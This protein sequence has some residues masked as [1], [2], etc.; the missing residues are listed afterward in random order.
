MPAMLHAAPQRRGSIASITVNY[1]ARANEQAIRSLVKNVAVM[2]ATTYSSGDPAAADR[3]AALGQRI[4][5]ELDGP[6]GSQSITEIEADLA[7]AQKTTAAATDRH[8]QTKNAL[9]DMLQQIE[10]VSND[11]VAAQI[12]T[13]QTRLQASLQTTSLLSKLSL[14]NYITP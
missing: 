12:L 6:A 4:G 9:D 3:D 2:A 5:S 7:G 8:Q 14:V 11:D 13:L 10:G 1:G